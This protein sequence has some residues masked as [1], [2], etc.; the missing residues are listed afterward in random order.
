MT[1]PRELMVQS[2]DKRIKK[3][4][5]KVHFLKNSKKKIIGVRF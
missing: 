2:S 5:E 1:N 3:T 4:G